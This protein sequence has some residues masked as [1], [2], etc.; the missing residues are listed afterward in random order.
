M[1]TSRGT[2]TSSLSLRLQKSSEL[3]N[4]T[5]LW[6]V[7]K[8]KAP[9]NSDYGLAQD[10]KERMLL[11][12]GVLM[13]C[14]WG[15]HPAAQCLFYR[16]MCWLFLKPE[17]PTSTKLLPNFSDLRHIFHVT[18]HIFQLCDGKKVQPR[19]DLMELS[20]YNDGSSITALKFGHQNLHINVF[21][22]L[23]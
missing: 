1:Q 7:S 18:Y 9:G 17:T 4:C 5:L 12:P 8:T 6:I 22:F 2:L 21:W 13:D 15:L 20:C 3:R 19:E 23:D 16:Q 14:C 10:A 11:F